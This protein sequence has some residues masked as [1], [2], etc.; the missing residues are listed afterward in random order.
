MTKKEIA[1]LIEKHH[2]LIPF[3]IKLDFGVFPLVGTTADECWHVGRIGLMRAA[4][5]R[6][7]CKT[8]FCCNFQ[9]SAAKWE[10][11]RGPYIPKPNLI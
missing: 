8:P 7:F 6:D 11:R 2:R 4:R 5:K 3:F 9:I 1:A 10:F